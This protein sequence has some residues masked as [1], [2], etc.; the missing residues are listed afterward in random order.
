MVVLQGWATLLV[1]AALGLWIFLASKN[2]TGRKSTLTAVEMQL[3]LSRARL[4]ELNE[5]SNLKQKLETEE[6]VMQKVGLHVEAS[7]LLAKLDEIMPRE[8]SLTDASF[9]TVEEVHSK[10]G[11]DPKDPKSQEVSRK[12]M[13]RLSGVTPSDADWAGVLAKLSSVPFFQ[14]VGLV[15]AKDKIDNGHLMREFQIQFVADLGAGE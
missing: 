14:D 13:V 4:K 6:R 10:P 5:Q 12:L 2:T 3:D 7:R 11:G 9:E 15:G 8:M 1:A